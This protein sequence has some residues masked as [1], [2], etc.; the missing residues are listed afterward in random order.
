[1]GQIGP[2]KAIDLL[3]VA[4]VYPELI[5]PATANLLA[6]EIG[7]DQVECFDMKEA[8]DGWMKAV[9]LAEALIETGRYRRVMVVNQEFSL[10]P[11]YAINPSLFKWSSLDQ[12]EW[13]FPSLTIGEAATAT[14]LG[15]D[16]EN[17]WR[18]SNTT[19]NDHGQYPIDSKRVAKDGPGVFSSYGAE[20]RL[21]GLPLIVK[22]FKKSGIK[23]D[24]V[25]I[26]F[27]HSSSKSDWA[28]A[29]RQMGLGDKIYDIY[30]TCGNVV[31]AAIPAAMALAVEDG[32]L[33]RG[34]KTVAL[35]ASAGMS[36]SLASF[37]F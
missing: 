37:K 9:K 14:I 34:A 18:F 26:L 1:M 2:E 5:E 4:S 11:G 28:E 6:H 25:D 8:C 10:V 27:T 31:S 30:A 12:M 23:P 29:A 36:F 33:K 32:T 19:R 17:V 21:H 35:V 7:L 15:P 13:R 3:I 22:E 16:P 20:L 24:E